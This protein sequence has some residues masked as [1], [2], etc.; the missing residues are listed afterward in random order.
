[1]S[2]PRLL[3]ASSWSYRP[4]SFF[5]TPK[6]SFYRSLSL[7]PCFPRFLARHHEYLGVLLLLRDFRTDRI[8]EGDRI[9]HPRRELTRFAIQ[10]HWQHLLQDLS[11]LPLGQNFQLI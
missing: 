11:S 6:I 5:P 7:L 1:M 10:I 3:L 8:F 4:L 2:S 9:L